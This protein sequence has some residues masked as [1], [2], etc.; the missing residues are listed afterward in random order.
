MTGRSHPSWRTTPSSSPSSRTTPSSV[1]PSPCTLPSLA[2]L[3]LDIPSTEIDF[4]ELFESRTGSAPA[5]SSSAAPAATATS[6]DDGDLVSILRA[7]LADTQLAFTS[8][9]KVVQD[10]L[11]DSLGLDVVAEVKGDTAE[12]AKPKARKEGELPKDSKGKERDDDSH[13]FESYAYNDIHEIMLKGEWLKFN[14]L[15]SRRS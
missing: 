1:R 9:K 5:A 7:Q 15:S 10:R 2:E 11:G 13:Y 14:R 8:L 6:P 4:D 3:T 12:V